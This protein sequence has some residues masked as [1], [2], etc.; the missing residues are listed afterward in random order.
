[1]LEKG[2]LFISKKTERSEGLQSV[3]HNAESCG[4]YFRRLYVEHLTIEK[5]DI[6]SVTQATTLKEEIA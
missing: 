3:V 1:M 5:Y 4:V 6:E 2:N